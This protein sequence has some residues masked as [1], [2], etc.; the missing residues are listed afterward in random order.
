[1]IIPPRPSTDEERV[2]ALEEYRLMDSETEA[3]Y[4]AIVHLASAICE[5]PISLIT[6]IDQDRQWYKAKT[7]IDGTETKRDLAFCAFTILDNNLM[8]VEDTFGD[9]RF[10]GHPSVD[11]DPYIRFYAGMPLRTPGGHNL[12]SLCVIDRVPRRLTDFQRKTL[13]TLGQQV[14]RLF[15]LRRK[16][17]ELRQ[18]HE[19]QNRLLS[20]IGHDL[21]TPIASINLLMDLCAD[22]NLGL[23]DFKRLVPEIRRS[24]ESTGLLI[25]NLTEW[26]SSQFKG[27][28]VRRSSIP[29]HAFT[30]RFLEDNRYLLDAKGN[31]AVNDVPAGHAVSADPD[32]V[33]FVL[34]NL[35]LNA[36]KFT[37]DGRITIGAEPDGFFVKDSGSGIDPSSI[38]DLFSFNERTTKTGTAGERGSGLGL[39]M[40]HEFVQAHGGRITVDSEPGKGSVFSVRFS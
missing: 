29:M 24:S 2:R 27:L 32:M 18:L 6:L 17:R 11:G 19:V 34:R 33:A 38:P 16:N 22:E 13:E 36:N 9:E 3:D 25:E 8:E 40:C 28:S 26:A 4:D 20:I 14:I 35:V 15:E 39:P 10:I 7:G 21:R 30:E 23:D 12:G 5:T 31:T 37:S 1:M